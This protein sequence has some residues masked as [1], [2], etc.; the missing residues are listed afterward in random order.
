MVGATAN[1]GPRA[2]HVM[3]L[4]REVAARYRVTPRTVES[5]T[6]SGKLNCIRIG[7]TVRYRLEDLP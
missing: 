2:E 4:K 7:H 5:W 3:L 6:R 1:L